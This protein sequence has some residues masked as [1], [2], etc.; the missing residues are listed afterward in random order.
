MVAVGVEL[1]IS[2]MH[3]AVLRSDGTQVIANDQGNR[4]TPAVVAFTEVEHLLGDAAKNQSNQKNTVEG[5]LVLLG[6]EWGDR[7]LSEDVC[8]AK[9]PMSEGKNGTLQLDVM[10]KGELKSLRPQQ[11]AS[12]LLAQARASAEAAIGAP[13]KEVVLALPAHLHAAA[14]RRALKEAATL[15]GMRVRDMLPLPLAAALLHARARKA[16]DAG[17]GA[18]P[19]V[20]HWLVVE[21]GGRSCSASVVQRLPTA[22]TGGSGED[23]KSAVDELSVRSCESELGLGGRLVDQRICSHVLKEIRRRQ[24]VD[25]SDNSR[26][27][28][29]LLRACE[30]AKHSLSNSTQATVTVE[31]DGIDYCCTVTRAALDDMTAP[32]CAQVVSLAQRAATRAGIELDAIDTLLLAGGAMR[33]PK[34]QAAISALVPHAAVGLGGMAEEV[35]AR[36]AALHGG[37]LASLPHP[38]EQ[39]ATLGCRA[40][41]PRA[42]GLDLGGGGH[43]VLA[44]AGS[45]LPLSC[46]RR[47]ALGGGG[48]GGALVR[49][50]EIPPSGLAVE[51]AREI[52]S[53]PLPKA[54]ADAAAGILRLDVA[55]DGSMELSCVGD[56]ASAPP[57]GSLHVPPPLGFALPP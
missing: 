35:A 54:P 55:E 29:R 19:A 16:V 11:I 45:A 23:A 28:A 2:N 46:S 1:G 47:I 50:V 18:P 48:G 31:A 17:G 12:L 14:Q 27:L 15:G 36:G 51:D 7:Q 38:A 13:V 6:R 41:L 34:L 10:A 53:L 49:L 24:R 42:L 9:V 32:L 3:V 40:V 39:T 37:L 4:S 44:H 22:A 57:L 30:G 26:A 20:E 43:C 25:L 56:D 33:M 21:V 5:V 52:A 8:A